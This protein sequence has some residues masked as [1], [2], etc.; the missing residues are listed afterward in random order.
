MTEDNRKKLMEM[1]HGNWVTQCLY[2][3][4][5]LGVA[6]LLKDGAKNSAD[7]A[8]SLD[9]HP[10]SIYRLLR[11][12]SGLGIFH[13]EADNVFTL[14]P[15]GELLKTES[16]NSLREYVI[17]IN[18]KECYQSWGQLLY[19]IKTGESAFKN[20]FG[21][22]FLDYVNNHAQFSNTFDRAMAQKYKGVISSII[23]AY[24][25][26]NFGTIVDIGGG[27]GNLLLEI[28]EKYPS[29][30]GVLFDLPHV[31]ESVRKHIGNL[32]ISDRFT[33]VAGDC[34]DETPKG[35]DAYVLKSFINNWNERDAVRVLGNC[36][37]AMTSG[38]K[39]II[40]EPVLLSRNQPDYGK[41]MDLQ[42]LVLQKSG[43][44]T[45]EEF[46]KLLKLSGFLMQSLIPTESEFS[47]IEAI[48]N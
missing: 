47:I 45:K 43:E 18:D 22:D 11:A 33:L 34:F 27:Y 23:K 6:D 42:L 14:T 48:I 44:R 5:K 3:A 1:I 31:I 36:R 8:R 16:P 46:E 7:L 2:V 37:K 41:L 38:G 21:E 15:L 10:A 24:D 12:L 29:V 35:G 9:A 20:V 32:D 26:S 4:A 39:L 28:L 40:I 13:E 30:R 25:F 17:M 19:S